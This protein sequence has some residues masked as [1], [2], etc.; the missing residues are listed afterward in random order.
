MRI[1]RISIRNFRGVVAC[2]VELSKTGVTI[3]EGPNEVGKSSLAMAI[4]LLFDFPHDSRHRSVLAVRPV[5]RDAGSEV[6]VEL[7]TGPYHVVYFKRWFRQP[8]TRLSVLAPVAESV[9]GRTAHDRMEAL[10]EETLDRNLYK[11]LRFVQGDRV[12]QGFFGESTTLISALDQATATGGTDAQAE[13]TLWQAIQTERDRYF[14]PTGRTS[15]QRE[16]LASESAKAD[17]EVAKTRA[18]LAELEVAGEAYRTTKAEL[19]KL[20]LDRVDAS[21]ELTQARTIRN[22]LAALEASIE[23]LKAQAGEAEQKETNADHA[24]RSRADK[25]KAVEDIENEINSLGGQLEAEQPQLST[26]EDEA[27]SARLELEKAEENRGTA[28]AS[29]GLAEGDCAFRRAEI[30]D[31]LLSRRVGRVEE[32]R[33]DETEARQFLESCKVTRQARTVVDKAVRQVT[34]ARVARDVGS[35]SVVLEALAEI[36]LTIDEAP[37]H[38][39][40]GETHDVPA[41][42]DTKIAV[43]DRLV[44]RVQSAASTADLQ[45][46]LAKV[47]QE[48]DRVVQRYGLDPADPLSDLALVLEQ[49]HDAENRIETAQRMKAD[50]LE[51]LSEE[52]LAAKAQNARRVVQEYPSTRPAMP[53]LPESVEQAEFAVEVAKRALRETETIEAEKRAL[54]NAAQGKINELQVAVKT[55]GELLRRQSE[56]HTKAIAELADAR[57]EKSDED[58]VANL[59][60]ASLIAQSAR[61]NRDQA[62]AELSGRDPGTAK[63]RLENAEKVIERLDQER[64]DLDAR[65]IE[66]ETTLRV[67]GS[68][69]L[70]AAIDEA[71]AEAQRL[72][73]EHEE[74]DRKAAAAWHLH[75]IFSR[76]RD[77]ARLA[78][79]AP[80]REQV[81]KLARLVFGV[82]VS[83]EVDPEDF[84]LVA[85]NLGGVVVPFDWLSTGT[86]EQLSVLA[87]LACAILVNPEGATG[88]VGVPVVLD[89]ALGNSDPDRLRD[90]APAFSAAAKQAQVIVLTCTP[91]RYAR[92]GDAK[93]IRLSASQH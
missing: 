17:A 1:H 4:D 38:L 24:A 54:L 19:A 92:V 33:R 90:L 32:A 68:A 29:L 3:I 59:E 82:D 40:Q 27:Q 6:E 70:Q 23:T 5:D 83:I 87:R 76:H 31:L 39:R 91:E 14:T 15:Q 69:D 30:S 36:D 10:L 49:R 48:L 67:K 64:Q 73:R 8:E 60:Q 45:T 85:R 34:E 25:V 77:A 7:T 55:K 61:N 80:Y 62:M 35:P 41:S 47:E 93:V 58:L 13:S 42:T 81:E 50:A 28:L 43:E 12:G 52:E 86:R 16:V 89:D 53:P 78:Y 20:S 63:L 37:L 66:L 71:E 18:A 22:E 79:V 44:V 9:V 26:V 74:L 65:R 84:S 11:A 75:E 56:A 21:E 46:E 72:R 2:E 88:D 57:R 51:D